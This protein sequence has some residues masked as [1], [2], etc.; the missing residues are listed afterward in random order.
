MSY[1]GENSAF[2]FRNGFCEPLPDCELT[3]AAVSKLGAACAAHF[4]R[5][6]A[7]C[8]ENCAPWLLH[9]LC[10]GISE[11]G[12]EAFLCENTDLQSFRHGLAL[13]SC[14]CGIY[15]TDNEEPRFYFFGE[16]G[17]PLS[18][19]ELNKIINTDETLKSCGGK[20]TTINSL[21]NIYI[22]NIRD[23]LNPAVKL[24]LDAGISCGC[25]SMRTLWQEFFSDT[26]DSLIFQ[27]SDDGQRV[28]AYSTELGFI[29]GERLALAYAIMLYRK[30]NQPIF[31]PENM[32]YAAA[33]TAQELGIELK[34]YPADKPVPPEASA[35]RFICDPLFA[36]TQLMQ[37]RNAFFSILK[38]IPRFASARR[39]IPSNPETE[40]IIG[41][42]IIEPYGQVSLSKSGKN[43]IS[44]LTQAYDAETA[45]ELCGSWEKKLRQLRVCSHY[46][47]PKGDAV[48]LDPLPK[49]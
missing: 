1:L 5:L 4:N 26:D 16:N 35:Q 33:E 49:G 24:P 13:I 28:N 43:R 46:S 31:F 22:N 18:E 11:C 44:I 37:D 27:I 29:S 32:H 30:N 12:K 47:E 48:P 34:I 21:R 2:S 9:A 15:I 40:S 6:A 39:E 38:E 20:I 7:G 23:S 41:K 8:S 17:F 19:D 25:R 42:T 36:I 3:S 14:S 45:A 10:S